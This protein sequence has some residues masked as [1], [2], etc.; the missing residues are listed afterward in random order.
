MIKIYCLKGVIYHHGNRC[1]FGHYTCMINY[2]NKWYHINDETIERV[3]EKRYTNKRCL[4][5]VIQSS[6]NFYF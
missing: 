3:D 4:F 6:I 5:T 1:F 2:Y